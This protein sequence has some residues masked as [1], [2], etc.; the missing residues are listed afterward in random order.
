[1]SNNTSGGDPIALETRPK[2]VREVRFIKHMKQPL[3]N[4]LIIPV[5]LL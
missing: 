1:M 5:H 2:G 3:F 4:L